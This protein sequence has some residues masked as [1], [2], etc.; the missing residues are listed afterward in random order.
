MDDSEKSREQLIAEL[1]ELRV[2]GGVQTEQD[3]LA[4]D[5]HERVK[6]LNCLYGLAHLIETRGNSLADIFQGAVELIPQ[7]YFFPELAFARLRWDGKVFHS[8]GFQESSVKLRREI[9]VRGACVGMLEVGYPEHPDFLRHSPFLTEEATLLG[10]LAESLGHT[11]DRI[12]MEEEARTANKRLEA[13]WGIASL[14]DAD[15]KSVSDHILA[16]ITE[17]TE[18]T[19]GFYGFI[20]DDESVMTIHSWSGEAMKHCSMQDKPTDFQISDAGVWAE[21]IRHRAPFILNHYAEAHA[22]KKG[23]PQGHV[24]LTNLLV[25][26]L[27]IKDRI[28]SVAAV[29]NRNTDYDQNDVAQLISFL[30]SIQS[31]IESKRKEE[32]LRKS[33]ERLEQALRGAGEGIIDWNLLT[34]RILVNEFF[35]EMLGYTT[36]DFPQLGIDFLKLAHPED[37][38][39]GDVVFR[40]LL[41]GTKTEYYLEQRFLTKK[42]AWKWILARGTIV[43][44]TAGGIALRYVGTHMDIT[45]RKRIEL[46]LQESAKKHRTIIETAMDGFWLTNLEGR[47]LEVNATYCRMSGY[48][49]QEL[50]SMSVSDLE[51]FETPEVTVM[52]FKKFMEEG[53]DRFETRHRRKDGSIFD[54]EAS[55]QYRP[56]GSGMCVA[57]LRDITGRKTAEAKTLRIS[58]LYATL[59]QC[60][61]AIVRCTQERELFS[62]VCRAAVVHGGMKMAWIGLVDEAT[63]MVIPVVS[64]GDGTEYLREIQISVNG[65]SPF[66]RGPTGTSIRENRPFWCQDYQHDPATVTWHQYGARFG[67]AASASIPLLREGEP[68]GS[69]TLYA[70]IVEAFDEDIRNL[71]VEMVSDINFALDNFTREEKR[72]Q[73]EDKNREL[74]AIVE[75]SDDAI[76]G[77][78]LEL[79]ITS[80]NRGA[81]RIYGYREDEILGQSVTVI[82]PEELHDDIPRFLALIKQGESI[83]HYETLRKRKDGVSIDVSI[84][85]SPVRDAENVIIGASTIARDVTEIKRTEEAKTNLEIQ[86]HQSQKMESV[87]RLAGGVAHDFNNMLGIILGHAEIAMMDVNGANPLHSNLVEIRNAAERSA[88][89]TRQLLA[90]ARK[91]TVAP[92]VVNLNEIVT[93]ML[94]MLRRLIG[95]NIELKWEP[96]TE[97]WLVKM[98][99]SQ[100]DQILANLCVNARDAIANVGKIAIETGNSTFDEVYGAFRPGFVPGDYVRLS[101]SDTGCGM[102]KEMI[103]RIF[104]PFFTTKEVGK[105]TGL[106]LSTVYGVVTQNNGFI[107]V[108]SEPGQ[109]TTFTIHLPRYVDTPE[110]AQTENTKTPTNILGYETILLVEDEPG[111]LS[112][113]A[114]LLEKQGYTV[115][116]TNTPSQAL[117]IAREYRDEIHLLL[118][119]VIMPEMNGLDLAKQMTALHPSIKHLFMSGYTADIIAHHGVLEEG[120]YFIPKPFS[121]QSLAT[122]IREALDSTAN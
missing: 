58:K 26:P 84:T 93:G 110:Q 11:I 87:G 43:A 115:L 23:L 90:F 69:F 70:D 86:L 102:D 16:M 78:N 63:E 51:A 95:E 83:E 50:L 60:N 17:M 9:L 31:I 91:Q 106:G 46:A 119:D 121:A 71:L 68:I 107:D 67:S 82:V 120:V 52:H 77:I 113:I 22:A 103:E 117:R 85:I 111:I 53:E 92:K 24:P 42:G 100:V 7:A 109:G 44:R 4:H 33:E 81:A 76:I 79:I 104:E 14:V 72:R 64:Y 96:N 38:K 8:A 2:C 55:V 65:D 88:N 12:Q 30:S 105:G 114:L 48:T 32:L 19:F 80:W 29:A 122:Q 3:R 59:S 47:L 74:A 5:L 49:E 62:Q 35:A 112:M 56:I 39:A 75:Y 36:D 6:E 10:T 15:T 57:F 108:Y 37:K 20:N 13:L 25:V 73:T 94:S 98:D 27:L 61:E 45:F 97:P 18:S 89:L 1:R 40:A 54:V 66:G 116:A 101:L 118:T 21:A 28:I 34:D 99:P 41:A